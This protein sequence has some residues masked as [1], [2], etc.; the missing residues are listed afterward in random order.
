L[1]NASVQGR[2]KKVRLV[3]CK[4]KSLLIIFFDIK[5]I[6][7]KEIVLAGQTIIFTYF[8]GKCAKTYED[9][10]LTLITKGLAVASRQRTISPGNVFT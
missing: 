8:C 7:Y 1:R 2:L 3:K 4:V 9:F 6:I 5:G 10:A